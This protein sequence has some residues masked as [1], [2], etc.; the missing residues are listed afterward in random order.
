MPQVIEKL[1]RPTGFEPVTFGFGGQHS[2]QLS[3]GR[4]GGRRIL[5]ARP[6][7]KGIATQP[8]RRSEYQHPHHQP[9][10]PDI[11]AVLAGFQSALA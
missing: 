8:V 5:L 7:S 3:Y 2:I 1:P 10:M 11:S 4:G 9:L 6:S